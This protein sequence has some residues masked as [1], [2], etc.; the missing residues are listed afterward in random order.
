MIFLWGNSRSLIFLD[1]LQELPN[2]KDKP[3]EARNI[4]RLQN[5]I[6]KIGVMNMIDNCHGVE[7]WNQTLPSIPQ[8]T[9][10]CK[11]NV[12]AG[13]SEKL[14]YADNKQSPWALSMWMATVALVITGID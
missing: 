1:L 3:V 13:F 12:A 5:K 7:I 9:H 4:A 10:S 8:I 14:G 11:P 6:K 2:T